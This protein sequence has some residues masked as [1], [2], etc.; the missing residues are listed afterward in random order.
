MRQALFGV[1]A[2][3]ETA[4]AAMT[5][6]HHGVEVE[7]V[8][9]AHPVAV[10]EDVPC[11]LAAAVEGAFGRAVREPEVLAGASVGPA[12]AYV[13]LAA[14]LGVEDSSVAAAYHGLHEPTAV[15][16][17]DLDAEAAFSYL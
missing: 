5:G 6:P 4:G 17:L 8:K 2:A 14:E 10:V 3:H 7:D 12:V 9:E 15:E 13:P 1:V 16:I 11:L